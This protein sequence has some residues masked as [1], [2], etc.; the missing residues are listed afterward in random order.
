[1]ACV[2][3]YERRSECI[4]NEGLL[5]GLLWYETDAYS[6]EEFSYNYMELVIKELRWPLQL[7]P[8]ENNDYLLPLSEAIYSSR[9]EKMPPV[10][11]NQAL[12]DSQVHWCV[13]EK[14]RLEIMKIMTITDQEAAELKMYV[15]RAGVLKKYLTRYDERCTK[16][17]SR[18]GTLGVVE[19]ELLFEGKK[20]QAEGVKQF[21]SL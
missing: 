5:K 2:Y 15:A 7:I 12:N 13:F 14:A 9:K 8:S 10:G 21:S 3:E 16:F 17:R 6:R 18:H 4:Q 19:R 20:L 1:M 11:E